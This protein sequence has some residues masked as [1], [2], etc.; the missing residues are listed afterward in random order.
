MFFSLELTI[1]LFFFV[2]RFFTFE[3]QWLFASLLREQ[4]QN[5]LTL[6]SFVCVCVAEIDGIH[7][8]LA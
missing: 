4:M 2:H 3:I 8:F 5:S 6:T 7:A 1:I